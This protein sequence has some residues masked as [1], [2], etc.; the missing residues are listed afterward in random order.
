MKIIRVNKDATMN[1]IELKVTSKNLLSKLNKNAISKGNKEI[2]ELYKWIHNNTIVKCYGWYDGEPGFENK[3][4]L[5][6]NGSSNFLEED[7][8]V[9]LLYGDIFLVCFKKN[10]IIDYTVPNYA[11]LFNLIHDGFDDCSENDF[12][13]EEG[14]KEEETEEDKHFIIHD[15]CDTDGDESYTDDELDEDTNEY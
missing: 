2:N 8:S 4:E 12:S 6:P 9:Q 11:E 5:I 1:D 10:K 3:H 7:S 15:S 14:E 13:E